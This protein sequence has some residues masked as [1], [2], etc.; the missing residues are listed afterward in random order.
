[1]PETLK[2]WD[3]ETGRELFSFEDAGAANIRPTVFDPAGRRLAGEIEG[4]R[5][6]GMSALK[7]WEIDSR[8]ELLTIARPSGNLSELAFSPDGTRLAA[9][10]G[11]PI[12]PG[13]ES[14]GE[15]VVWDASSGEKIMQFATEPGTS[16][17]RY[18]PDGDRLGLSVSDG[19][20]RIHDARTGKSVLRLTEAIGAHRFS[21][22]AD[23]NSLAAASQGGKVRIWD[24]STPTPR[25]SRP[26]DRVLENF[27]PISHV[28]W[29]ARGDGSSPP[30]TR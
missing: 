2:A 4:S 30:S 3:C 9:L 7:V 26:P 28:A 19:S 13:R 20:I 22:S 15:A 12:R 6:R 17:L 8:E 29:S 27:I 11:P 21:F 24:V 14:A 18:S 25:E 16:G 23:G 1:M 10:T 5:A